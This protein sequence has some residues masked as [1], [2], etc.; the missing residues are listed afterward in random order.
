MSME[1]PNVPRRAGD[2][3]HVVIPYS[4]V[5]REFA[6]RLAGTLRRDGVSPWIDEVDMSAGVSL[7]TRILKA[8]RPIDFV[9]PI[10]SATSVRSGWVQ[11]ELEPIMTKELAGRVVVF[12]ARVD[13]CPLA[14]F[15]NRRPFADFH[16]LG[17]NRAYESVKV[18]VQRRA[19]TEPAHPPPAVRPPPAAPR[20]SAADELAPPGTKRIFLSYDHENDGNL[21]DVLVTWSKQPGFAHFSLYEQPVTVPVDSGAAEPLKRA[22][23]E[24]IGAASGFLCVVGTK[25]FGNPWVEWEIKK[26]DELGKRMV[27]VRVNRDCTVPE[28]LSDVAATCAMSFTFEGIRKAIDEAYGGCS[29]E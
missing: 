23:A 6:G 22:I 29:L 15:L 8:T 3:P 16:G 20:V 9:I 14:A 19:V 21:K 28:V 26:A 13:G 17:W 24:R 7:T 11:R 1:F 12:P 27:A 18:R 5:D 2:Q 4:F 10:I 25:T